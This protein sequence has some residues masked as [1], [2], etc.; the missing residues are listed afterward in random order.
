MFRT[1]CREERDSV[2]GILWPFTPGVE[3]AIVSCGVDFVGE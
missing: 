1:D 2:W 3:T